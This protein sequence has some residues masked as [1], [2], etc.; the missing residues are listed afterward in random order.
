L[1][2]TQEQ[3]E[4]QMEGHAF[5]ARIYAENPDMGFVPDSGEL[6]YLRTPATSSTVRIDAGFVEGD[7]ISPHYDPMIAKLIVKGPDRNAALARL[8]AALEEYEVVGP[9]TNIEFLKRLAVHPSFVAGDVETGFIEKH[10]ESLF[11]SEP[12]PPEVYS[13]AAMS[14]VLNQNLTPRPADPF[15]VLGGNV[16]FAGGLQERTIEFVEKKGD[17]EGRV[18][19]AIK[20]TGQDSYDVTVNGEI[21]YASVTA[22]TSPLERCKV[23]GFYP[24]TRLETTVVKRDDT[25]VIF[26][27]GKQYRVEIP[28][29]AWFE[30]APVLADVANSVP[31][32]MPCKVLQVS[33]KP[34]EGV[35]KDMPLAVIEGIKVETVSPLPRP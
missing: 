29:P 16:G 35:T 22:Y 1:P 7:V 8:R 3:I 23:V 24:H 19:V 30:K 25:L 2:L 28:R 14:V 33:V 12:T 18:L 17:E 9:S 13:Q 10:R 34:W 32:P 15:S 6:L 21:S 26:Q 27:R 5:E 31:A 11:A 4:R 20:Q